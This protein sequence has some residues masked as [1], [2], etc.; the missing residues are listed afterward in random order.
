MRGN[1]TRGNDESKEPS[2]NEVFA[3]RINMAAIQ[4]YEIYLP[5]TLNDGTPVEAAKIQEIKDTLV[6]AFG[7]YT[8]LNHRSEGAWRMGGVTFHDEVI[9]VR[10]LDDGSAHFDMTAFK[11]CIETALQ[12]EAVLIISRQVAAL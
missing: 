8:H 7:G 6:K 3:E 12:Q 11:E 2:T 9:I 4:E 1:G 5:T 10:V